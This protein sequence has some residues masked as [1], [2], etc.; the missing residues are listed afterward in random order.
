[1]V[2]SD[3]ARALDKLN[4]LLACKI[5]AKCKHLD[6]LKLIVLHGVTLPFRWVFTHIEAHQDNSIAFHLLS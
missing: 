5:S 2:Y 1:M 6:I 3:C 4:N